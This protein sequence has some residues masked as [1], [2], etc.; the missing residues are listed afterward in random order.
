MLAA[1]LMIAELDAAAGAVAPGVQ[2]DVHPRVCTLSIDMESCSTVLHAHWRSPHDQSLC[3][4]VVG[5]PQIKRCWENYSEG[6]YMAE[7]E[8][9]E[10][11]TVE[12][13]DLELDAVLAAKT[14]P[15]IKETQQ[16]RHRRRDP[17][18]IIY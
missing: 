13:R 10:D 16:Y 18:N 1:T 4:I 8:F 6:S 3:L 5:Q 17:W 11:L 9:K 2:F 15:V 7:L 14:I 12:L